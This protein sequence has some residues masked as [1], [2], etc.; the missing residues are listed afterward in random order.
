MSSLTPMLKSHKYRDNLSFNPNNRIKKAIQNNIAVHNI[1]GRSFESKNYYIAS[2]KHSDFGGNLLVEKSNT[3]LLKKLIETEKSI[4]NYS[5]EIEK[6]KNEYIQAKEIM[7]QLTKETSDLQNKLNDLQIEQTTLL[8]QIPESEKLSLHR[9]EK[10]ELLQ[11]KEL[12]GLKLKK[13]QLKSILLEEDNAIKRYKA[14]ISKYQEINNKSNTQKL[15]NNTNDD[16]IQKDI[17][18]LKEKIMKLETQK[19]QE[20]KD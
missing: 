4:L 13:L 3:N 19:T 8:A 10:E 11:E 5:L 7:D 1:E 18:F 9:I 14:F 6:E 17:E 20:E 15:F 12:N 16:S 2:E